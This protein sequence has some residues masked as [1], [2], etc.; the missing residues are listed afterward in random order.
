[1]RLVTAARVTSQVTTGG[2]P[3]PQPSVHSLILSA[4]ACGSACTPWT[5]VAEKNAH[6]LQRMSVKPF[7]ANSESGTLVLLSIPPSS[8]PT[9]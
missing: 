9:W 8:T 5:R 7:A 3:S 1:M 2:T 6:S 4:L